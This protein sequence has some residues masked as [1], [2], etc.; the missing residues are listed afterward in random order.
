MLLVSLGGTV[1][2]NLILVTVPRVNKVEHALSLEVNISNV[3]VPQVSLQ[4]LFK[5]LVYQCN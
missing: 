1:K 2:S 3:P 5:L 4:L